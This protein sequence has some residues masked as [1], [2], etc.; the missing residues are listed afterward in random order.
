MHDAEEYSE[1]SG[2]TDVGKIRLEVEIKLS[3]DRGKAS[4]RVSDVVEEDVTVS[5]VWQ[6]PSISTRERRPYYKCEG[7]RPGLWLVLLMTLV[8]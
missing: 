1:R 3:V 4:S 2:E 8:R 7:P 5:I 6:W